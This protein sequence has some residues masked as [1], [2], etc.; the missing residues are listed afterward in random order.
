[1]TYVPAKGKKVSNEHH[2][3]SPV[4]APLDMQ[5]T[6]KIPETLAQIAEDK[7]MGEYTDEEMDSGVIVSNKH[8]PSAPVL[9]PKIPH[10]E[11]CWKLCLTG[12]YI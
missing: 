10:T 11:T 7:N 12:E 6:E 4:L 5:K 1:M 8:V 9:A 2:P 3:L